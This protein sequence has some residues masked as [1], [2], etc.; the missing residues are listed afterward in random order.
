MKELGK[1][2]AASYADKSKA[3][4]ALA[5]GVSSIKK[6]ALGFKQ[7]GSD[8][9]KE[10]PEFAMVAKAFAYGLTA[11]LLVSECTGNETL[12]G[13]TGAVATV[14]GV[15]KDVREIIKANEQQRA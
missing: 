13:I 6:F 14:A 1:A 3:I 7:L 4:A 10:N 15:A 9:K 8:F 11:G 2:G 12:G 5:A